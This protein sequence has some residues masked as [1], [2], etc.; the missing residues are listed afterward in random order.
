MYVVHTCQVY[1]IDSFIAYIEQQSF[2]DTFPLWIGLETYIFEPHY[3][4]QDKSL[5]NYTHFVN[6]TA[7]SNTTGSSCFAWL[8]TVAN[9][10]WIVVDCQNPLP[11]IC[12][13]HVP[14]GNNVYLNGSGGIITSP[15]YPIPYEPAV[16]SNYYINVDVQTVVDLTFIYLKIDSESLIYVY[17][18]WDANSTI[19]ET[20]TST[21]RPNMIE[22]SSNQVR[23][24]FVAS[25]SGGGKYFGWKASINAV[26]P[27]TSS[28]AFSSTNYP[29][30]SNN[31]TIEQYI[32]VAPDYGI[33]FYVWDYQS[34]NGSA[35]LQITSKNGSGVYDFINWTAGNYT[36][37]TY[38]LDNGN[39]KFMW[40]AENH[41]LYQ[42]RVNITWIAD[43][44]LLKN[45]P[46]KNYGFP[47]V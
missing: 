10:G 37:L 4:W 14:H 33:I 39:A 42:K 35:Q 1:L 30:T 41:S 17:D 43:P 20:I 3:R 34:E 21:Y 5:A 11:F 45:S 2:E 8:K 23:V 26:V 31:E 36:N 9:D 13:R 15:K 16:T 6:G 38:R 27:I 7:P 47:S 24:E 25:G 19:I 32:R 12:K 40:S 18:G 29:E 28:G 46:P 22:S 44:G